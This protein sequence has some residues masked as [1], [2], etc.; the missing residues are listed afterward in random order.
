MKTP[1]DEMRAASS[2]REHYSTYDRWLT[3]QD[4]AAMRKRRE[5]SESRTR[6][7]KRRLDETYE[8]FLVACGK[9]NDG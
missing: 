9:V 7:A 5:D 8:A 3:A 2:V 6:A 4:D 1:F